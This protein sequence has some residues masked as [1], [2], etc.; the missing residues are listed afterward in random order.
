MYRLPC[1]PARRHHEWGKDKEYKILGYHYVN[2][3]TDEIIKINPSVYSKVEIDYNFVNKNGLSKGE[4][5]LVN[6]DLILYDEID[7]AN[8]KEHLC[9]P[10]SIK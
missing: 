2:K 9:N 3:E 6:Q 10:E 7:V 4:Y 8:D 1:Y 5:D